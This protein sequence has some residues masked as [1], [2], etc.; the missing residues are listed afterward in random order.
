MFAQVLKK[1]SFASIPLPLLIRFRCFMLNLSF[2]CYKQQ[3][4]A[5]VKKKK[6]NCCREE[7]PPLPPTT[8]TSPAAPIKTYLSLINC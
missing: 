6:K 8:P 3:N 2:H 1:S 7:P 5:C 4:M